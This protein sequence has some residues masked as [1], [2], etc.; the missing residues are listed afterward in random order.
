MN[1]K[2][3]YQKQYEEEKKYILDKEDEKSPLFS[4]LRWY[5]DIILPTFIKVNIKAIKSQKKYQFGI[6]FIYLAST[7]IVTLV[8]IQALFFPNIFQLIWIEVLIILI[9]LFV[10]WQSKKF[11]YHQNWLESRFLAEKLRNLLYISLF[12]NTKDS[13]NVE[14]GSFISSNKSTKQWKTFMKYFSFDEKPFINIIKHLQTIKDFLKVDWIESQIKYHIH[15]GNRNHK[16]LKLIE[17]IGFCFLIL[18]IGVAISHA[19]G[20]GH[21]TAIGDVINSIFHFSSEH[22]NGHNETSFTIGN[23]LTI[24]A[25]FFPALSASL[26]AIKHTL[27]YQKMHIRS[28]EIVSILKDFKNMIDEIKDE[29]ELK[30]FISSVEKFFMH[31]HEE[32]ITLVAHKSADVG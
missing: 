13:I 16:R 5:C 29:E 31:E 19:L 2:D 27:E 15:T 4:H 21:H 12:F 18:T 6:T 8:I 32:W 20:I 1:K 10:Q 17:R 22:S 25:L 28:L 14:R 7:C 30:N 11:A 3:F 26:N 24:F 23:L 9:M